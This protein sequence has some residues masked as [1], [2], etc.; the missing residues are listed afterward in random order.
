MSERKWWVIAFDH[1]MSNFWCI[2]IGDILRVEKIVEI[3]RDK[4]IERYRKKICQ[5]RVFYC[6]KNI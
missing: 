2:N 1:E 6:V 5:R 3:S 4:D